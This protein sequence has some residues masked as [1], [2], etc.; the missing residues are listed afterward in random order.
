MFKPYLETQIELES[1]L[2][3]EKFTQQEVNLNLGKFKTSVFFSGIF[4]NTGQI[5][6]GF[7][8]TSEEVVMYL[9]MLFDMY[10]CYKTIIADV[11]DFSSTFLGDNAKWVD[12]CNPSGNTSRIT[13]KK[14]EI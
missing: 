10:D 14:W 2:R 8:Y 1:T 3:L 9:T 6:T 5:C 13:I 7:G 12:D 11:C 4:K